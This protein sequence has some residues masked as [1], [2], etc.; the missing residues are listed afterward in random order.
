MNEVQIHGFMS[1]R[2]DKKLYRL[3]AGPL[4]LQSA[5]RI[6]MSIDR[7]SGNQQWPVSFSVH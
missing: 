7:Y 4:L 2:C 5:F 3:S 6:I 1:G